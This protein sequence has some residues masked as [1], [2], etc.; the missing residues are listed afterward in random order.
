MAGL[1]GRY[2][3]RLLQAAGRPQTFLTA[4]GG[5]AIAGVEVILQA[6]LMG[7]R[8]ILMPRFHPIET[9]MAAASPVV[10]NHAGPGTVGLAYSFGV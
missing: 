9:L 4:V 7:D 2:G 8:L 1:V 6:L 3:A 10:G 5:Y